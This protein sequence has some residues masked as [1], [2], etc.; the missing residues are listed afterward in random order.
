MYGRLL[1]GSVRRLPATRCSAWCR[2]LV[3]AGSGRR[4]VVES[5]GGRRSDILDRPG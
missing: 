3:P 2:R 5:R 1:R 4:S